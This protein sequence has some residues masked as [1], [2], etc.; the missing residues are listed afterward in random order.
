MYQNSTLFMEC[1]NFAQENMVEKSVEK[2]PLKLAKIV[3][4]KV[5][6]SWPKNSCEDGGQLDLQHLIYISG[7]EILQFLTCFG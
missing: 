1:N 7:Y 2:L 6:H 5:L 4:W 3:T